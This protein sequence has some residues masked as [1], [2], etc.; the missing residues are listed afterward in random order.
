MKRLEDCKEYYKSVYSSRIAYDDDKETT[1][2]NMFRETLS[3][4]YG[5]DFKVIENLWQ[6]EALNELY[7]NVKIG[8]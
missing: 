5:Y 1:R 8:A 3:F 4:I 6:Q 2:F 7:S